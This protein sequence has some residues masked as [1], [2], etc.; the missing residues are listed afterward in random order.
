MQS[1]TD[2][3][4]ALAFLVAVVLL[5]YVFLHREPRLG[6]KWRKRREKEGGRFAKD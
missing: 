3:I 4:F 6:E 1:I 5:L 2:L